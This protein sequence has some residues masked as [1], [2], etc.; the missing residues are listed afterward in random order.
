MK[1]GILTFH[2]A[3]NYGA[4][5][6]CYALSEHLKN[7]GHDV[8]VI[9][10]RAKYIEKYRKRIPLYDVRR[11]KG[12]IRKVKELVSILFT[13]KNR[14]EA[15]ERFDTFLRQNFTFSKPFI[16]AV[17][18]P[19]DYDMVVLGSDQIWS[20]QI[21]DGFDSVY[22]GQFQHQNTK[23]IT[24]AA[25]LGGHNELNEKEWKTVGKYLQSF[26]SISVRERQLQNDLQK[27]LR[28]TSELVVDPT[29]LVKEDVFERI[30]EK[31]KN[32]PD[33]YVL[34]FSVAPTDNLTG[35]A[36]K[37]ASQTDSE[38]VWLTA[39]KPLRLRE[40]NRHI[41]VNPTV[42]EFLG[43]FKYAK[44]IVTVSFHGT[45]FSVLFR[46]DFYSL[47]NYMQ[48]RAE[49]LLVSIG[50]ADRLQKSDN[51]TI[52]KIIFQKVDYTGVDEKLNS[53]RKQSVEYL[54]KSIN[55]G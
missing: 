23:L 28:I 31:P 1:I 43:W 19:H 40:A 5:L 32:M 4:V 48:D 26:S 22:W 39:N 55:N 20:P 29:L 18:F 27:R 8:D 25:S 14:K 52:E 24:Y 51:E 38:I 13:I 34:V 47:A 11:S 17:N 10:Y 7:M 30:V 3:I 42:G 46:K 35:F 50:L 2:R 53:I 21:C 54:K 36:E 44:C 37:I 45:V 41:N 33:N 6:Q 15:K 9:D 16:K 49:Q 12:F